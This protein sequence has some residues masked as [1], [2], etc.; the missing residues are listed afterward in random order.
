MIDS[1]PRFLNG[2]FPFTGMGYD[3]PAM[4]DPSLV[5]VVPAD[6][7]AQLIYLRGGNS[8][9][10][11]AYITL[12]QDGKPARIFPLGAKAGIHVPLAVVE[13]LQPDTRIEVF[14]GAAAAVT[15]TLVLDLGIIEI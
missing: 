3:K 7:R 8:S 11:L 2:A 9:A 13:D 10:E 1:T 4:L 14:F 5:Y 6:K 12:M 15:G